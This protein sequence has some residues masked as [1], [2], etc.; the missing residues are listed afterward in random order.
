MLG[1]VGRVGNVGRSSAKAGAT[2]KTYAEFQA[3]IRS[4]PNT[5]IRTWA[6]EIS[7]AASFVVPAAAPSGSMSGSSSGGS[8]FGS[9][10][11]IA[12]TVQHR[13]P[14]RTTWD[15]VVA[16]GFDVWCRTEVEPGTYTIAGLT[17][18]GYTST[19][20]VNNAS[21]LRMPE[22]IYWYAGRAWRITTG[23]VPEL[24]DW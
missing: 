3:H 13:L 7:F 9:G 2:G 5:G 12:R 22:C 15:A 6:E 8:I 11:N 19:T 24:Y 14:D 23:N 21:N 10:A 18:H 20:A 1:A 17:K 4:I 16:G